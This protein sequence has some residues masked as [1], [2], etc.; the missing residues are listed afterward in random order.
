LNATIS[1]IEK[2]RDKLLK[3]K[4]KEVS[5]KQEVEK[6]LNQT[7]INFDSYQKTID[8]TIAEQKEK[9]GVLKTKLENQDLAYSKN[10]TQLEAEKLGLNS[11]ITNQQIELDNLVTE[12]N[13]LNDDL[14]IVKDRDKLEIT[15]LKSENKNYKKQRD[16]RADITFAEYEELLTEKGNL[17][18]TLTKV[19]QNLTEAESKITERDEVIGKLEEDNKFLTATNQTY[20]EFI[21]ELTGPGMAEKIV[22]KSFQSHPVESVAGAGVLGYL[23]KE[24]LK[25]WRNIPKVEKL[26]SEKEELS[27]KIRQLAGKLYQEKIKNKR[28]KTKS[29]TLFQKA[30]SL[31][32]DYEEME[33][34]NENNKESKKRLYQRIKEIKEIYQKETQKSQTELPSLALVEYRKSQENEESNDLF[35]SSLQKNFGLMVKE[36]KSLQLQNRTSPLT[37]HTCPPCNLEHCSHS[38]YEKLKKHVC[39]KVCSETYHQAIK[40]KREKEVINQ[41][42]T[43]CRLGCHSDVNLNQLISKIKELI[44]TP[45]G[46]S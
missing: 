10:I 37:S 3:D 8:L 11:T 9:L 31:K 29:Q 22:K 35:N 15:R 39:P 1:K 21:E 25:K 5:A 42:N 30:K 44:S 16:G 6:T 12:I 32:E 18:A 2:E 43:E 38:D 7:R 4:E 41:I 23:T 19:T 17:N 24:Y 13:K 33:G 46:A 40:L 36:I 27:K 28:L 34:R 14:L 20:R 45:D 26:E